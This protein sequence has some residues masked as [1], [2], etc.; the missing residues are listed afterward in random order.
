MPKSAMK[1]K[2]PEAGQTSIKHPAHPSAQRQVLE[3]RRIDRSS[4]LSVPNPST[5]ARQKNSES[6]R[7]SLCR[8]R[9]YRSSTRVG[10]V[11]PLGNTKEDDYYRNDSLKYCRHEQKKNQKKKKIGILAEKSRIYTGQWWPVRRCI[12]SHGSGEVLGGNQPGEQPAEQ[13]SRPVLVMMGAPS[14]PRC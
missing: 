7:A 6:K 3:R 1:K 4:P 14:G 8:C 9:G 10:S 2:K 11:A 12:H 13:R 5:S